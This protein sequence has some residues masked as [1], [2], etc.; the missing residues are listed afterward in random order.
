MPIRTASKNKLRMK[1]DKEK[2]ATCSNGAAAVLGG[3]ATTLVGSGSG[4]TKLIKK[5]KS[6]RNS[7]K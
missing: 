5:N 1:D 7:K 2:N 3:V 4:I 6:N